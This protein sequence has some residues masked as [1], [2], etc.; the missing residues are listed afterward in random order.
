ML[1]KIKRFISHFF[2]RKI[3]KLERKFKTIHKP[4][5]NKIKTIIFDTTNYHSELCEISLKF[6][7]DK[8]PYNNAGGPGHRHAYTGIYDYLF[9]GIKNNNLNFC[10]IGIYHNEG[11]KIFREYFKNS[12]IYGFDSEISFIEKGKKD[13]LK[14]VYY[15]LID[16]RDENSLLN[17]FKKLNKKFDIIIDDSTHDFD[18]QI[19]IIKT[20]YHFMKKDSFLIIE[21]IYKKKKGYYDTDYYDALSQIKCLSNYSDYYF[22]EAKHKNEWSRFWDNSKLLVLKKN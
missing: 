18:D 7:S 16:V 2:E 22:I 21:D 10:E 17:S 6:N 19:R 8:S 12:K 1:I 3:Y 9:K 5:Y 13:N 14:N 15:N 11:I 20:A 4:S